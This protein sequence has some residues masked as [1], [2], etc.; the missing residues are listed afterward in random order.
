MT[1]L[2]GNL[3]RLFQALSWFAH[4]VLPT[5]L[6]SRSDRDSHGGSR[7]ARSSD[8][9]LLG[10][11]CRPESPHGDGITL[12]WF[13]GA[14]LQS[15]PEDNVL[16]L[17]VQRSGKTSTLVVPTLLC[18]D[19]AA[20]ATSTKEE[21]VALTAIHR[22]KSGRIWVFAPLDRDHGWLEELDLKPATWNPV[23]AAAS[24]GDAA[25]L[26]DHFTAEG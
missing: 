5:W 26:A 24:C 21:L 22:R 14:L 6:V 1:T 19:G 10:R 11:T 18:W 16:A 15:P 23:L 13:G 4:L 7:W 8:A 20:V 2:A 25:E 3:D 12:G 9:E 17:G